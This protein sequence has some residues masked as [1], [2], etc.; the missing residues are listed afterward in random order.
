M[1]VVEY[2]IFKRSNVP[3]NKVLI[4]PNPFLTAL[5]QTSGRSES[6]KAKPLDISK[7]MLYLKI[8]IDVNVPEFN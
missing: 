1:E 4:R 8:L 7:L 6:F 3:S 5:N 2:I